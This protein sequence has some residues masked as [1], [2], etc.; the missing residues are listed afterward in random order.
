MCFSLKVTST[1]LCQNFSQMTGQHSLFSYLKPSSLTPAS[2]SL[3]HE[4]DSEKSF[5]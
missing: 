2:L 1:A 5:E 3:D 4:N